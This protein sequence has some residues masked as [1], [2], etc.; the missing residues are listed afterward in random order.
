MM[1]TEETVVA[2]TCF[3]VSLTNQASFAVGQRNHNLLEPRSAARFSE[4]HLEVTAKRWQGNLG[5]VQSSDS[6]ICAFAKNT[7][8]DVDRREVAIAAP[9]C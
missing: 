6:P 8:G 5:M 2:L 9:S 4:K 1:W 7:Q 3:D